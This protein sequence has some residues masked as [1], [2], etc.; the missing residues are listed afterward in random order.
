[1]SRRG[2]Y[3]VSR[4]TKF[5]GRENVPLNEVAEELG[6]K[7]KTVY[8]RVVFKNETGDDIERRHMLRDKLARTTTFRGQDNVPLKDVAKALGIPYSRVF[9]SC[10]LGRETGDDLEMDSGPKKPYGELIEIDGVSR[11]RAEWYKLNGL[12]Q[13]VVSKRIV[14]LGWSVEKALTTPVQAKRTSA[15]VLDADL[16][17]CS[18]VASG[19]S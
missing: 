5:R 18:D 10:A 15:S 16:S 12:S 4:S 6:L 14:S 3:G 19:G 13:S 2:H 8:N 17:S 1:M 11:T 7:Y 9:R